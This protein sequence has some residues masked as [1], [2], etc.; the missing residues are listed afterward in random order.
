MVEKNKRMECA[1]LFGKVSQLNGMCLVA[2]S[3]SAPALLDDL[4]CYAMAG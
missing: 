2:G 3:A 4:F 1:L